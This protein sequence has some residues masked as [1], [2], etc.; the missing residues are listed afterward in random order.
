MKR[1]KFV[2]M[3]KFVKRVNYI[4]TLQTLTT[5]HQLIIRKFLAYLRK[6]QMI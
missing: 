3:S 6:D 2:K 4:G 1:C 5:H